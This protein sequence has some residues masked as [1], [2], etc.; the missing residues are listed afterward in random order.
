MAVRRYALAGARQLLVPDN[1]ARLGGQFGGPR[2]GCSRGFQRAV[3][4]GLFRA[5]AFGVA[6]DVVRLGCGSRMPGLDLGARHLGDLGLLGQAGLEELF[7]QSVELRREGQPG[8]CIWS[9]KAC[10]PAIAS[11]VS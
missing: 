3:A 6:P 11:R 7:V 10:I 9:L 2:L 5:L 8:P 1:L 4:F